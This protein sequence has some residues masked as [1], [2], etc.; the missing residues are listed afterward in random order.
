MSRSDAGT[1][2]YL[3]AG[4]RRAQLLAAAAAM[5]GR[6]G[7]GSLT[8]VGVAAEAGV[9]RQWL[10]EHFADLD[11]L[12][13]ALVLDRFAA[14]DAAVDAAKERVSGTDLAGLAARQVFALVPADRRILRALVDGAGGN[15]PELAGIADELRERI[16]GRWTG[17]VRRTGRTEIEARAIVWSVV[18]AVF[19]LADQIE[20]ESLPVEQALSILDLIVANFGGPA[21]AGH[22]ATRPS[23]EPGTFAVQPIIARTDLKSEEPSHA[24]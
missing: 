10:Y 3:R 23:P 6:G 1:R 2:P 14:L 11:G 20:R 16:L 5:V 13:R 22:R 9:S 12:Y 24:H 4:E 15:R 7:L 8:M 17:F 21:A 19:G 18:N